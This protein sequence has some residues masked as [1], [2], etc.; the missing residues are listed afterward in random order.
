MVT[1]RTASEWRRDQTLLPAVSDQTFYWPYLDP[2]KYPDPV[3][4]KDTRALY[5]EVYGSMDNNG[6]PSVSGADKAALTHIT[7]WGSDTTNGM[8]AY[9]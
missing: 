9:S 1:P 5:S 3:H 7:V 4:P 2:V 8:D 6:T